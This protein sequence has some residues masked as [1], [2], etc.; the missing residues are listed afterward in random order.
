MRSR[1]KLEFLAFLLPV[2]GAVL[3][4]PPLVLIANVSTTVFGVPAIIAYLFAVWLALV[5]AAF[6]L[7]RALGGLQETEVET[8]ISQ[9]APGPGA[10][11]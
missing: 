7:Q 8:E 10:H 1:R 3:I 6:V 11:K 2:G 5:V 9:P 4:L